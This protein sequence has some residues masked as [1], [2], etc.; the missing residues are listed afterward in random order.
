MEK[1]LSEE[2]L[3][4]IE[5]IV[6][7][8]HSKLTQ[9]EEMIFLARKEF[10]QVLQETGLIEF[11]DCSQHCDGHCDGHCGEHCDVHLEGCC[12]NHE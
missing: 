10:M 8:Y 3:K 2:Q 1:E 12:N 9:A 5:T 11:E 4:R 7:E 6:Q